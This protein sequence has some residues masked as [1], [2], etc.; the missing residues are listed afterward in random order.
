[1]T[2]LI[3]IIVPVYNV[4][5][6]LR[7]CMEGLVGQTLR[8]IEIICVDDGSTDG[9]SAILAE[10]AAKDERVRVITQRNVGTSAARDAGLDATTAPLIMFCDSDD[11]YALCMC[12]KMYAAMQNGADIAACGVQEV[13]EKTW[14]QPPLSKYFRLP[15]IGEVA[16][17]DELLLHCDVCCVSKIYRRGILKEKSLRFPEGLRYED[18][19]FYACYT[20]HVQRVCFLDETLYFYRRHRESFMGQA[21]RKKTETAIQRVKIANKIWQYYEERQIV[22]KRLNYLLSIW[23]RLCA[24]SLSVTR[25]VSETQEIENLIVPFAK[26]Y[27]IPHIAHISRLHKERLELLLNHQ[28]IG[29]RRRLGGM[30]RLK[31][32]ERLEKIPGRVITRYYVCGIPCGKTTHNITE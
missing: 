11:W 25:R 16:A 4:Q 23:L 15:A 28:W 27:I 32:R 6:Y 1:M 13:Y 17:N 14:N 9:S 18:E 29:I 3:S 7:Q 24:E 2:P 31:T 20:A 12:E 30:V 5:P 22:E 26:E 10:Y 21:G 8:D 19:F